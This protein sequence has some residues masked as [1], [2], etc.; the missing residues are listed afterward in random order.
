M[1]PRKYR[2]DVCPLCKVNEETTSRKKVYQCSYC[3]R[4]LCKKHLEPRAS[5]FSPTHATIK[6]SA[7]NNFIEREWKNKDGHPDY[8]YTKEK[9]KELEVEE[10]SKTGTRVKSSPTE[11][12]VNCPQCRSGRLMTTASGA[13]FDAFKCSDCGYEWKRFHGLFAEKPRQKKKI[14]TKR[15]ATLLTFIFILIVIVLNGPII[16]S[17]FQNF[18][19]QSSYTKVTV[20]VGQVAKVE[21]DDNIY[22]FGYASGQ[23]VVVTPL[24]ELR[25][26]DAVEGA[27]YSDLG[28]EIVVSEVYSD[29]IVLLVKPNY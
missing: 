23:F 9:M 12:S 26:Y 10:V 3:E 18:M 27:V 21:F 5:V 28:I 16:Y 22:G 20:V 1:P 19:Q 29:Y 2:L 11:T 15:L 7:W 14:S 24:F 4:W 8:V 25:Y 6:D 17:A 13:Q